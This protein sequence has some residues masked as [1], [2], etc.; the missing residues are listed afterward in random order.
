MPDKDFLENYNLYQ[1]FESEIPER[2]NDFDK[3]FGKPPI[4]MICDICK[5][6]QTFS[7]NTDYKKA[8]G[9]DLSSGSI[10]L[11]DYLCVG[12]SK[13]HRSF[14]VKVSDK[15]DYFMKVGQNPAI[16]ISI[17]K[18]LSKVLGKHEE[19]YRKGLINERQG[20]GIGA[21]A[22]YRRI[23]ESTIDELLN[24]IYD[25]VESTRKDEYRYSLEKVKKTT[26]ASEKISFVKDLLPDKLRPDGMNPLGIL[27][28]SLSGGIH[29]KSDEDCL[30]ISENIRKT[31]VYLLEQVIRSKQESKEFAESMRR[32]L[33]KNAKKNS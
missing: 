1:K 17:D 12:C 7:M 29:D 6:E 14:L 9:S 33:E 20:Y 3:T 13:F 27:Y 8:S 2:V 28:A 25:F 5:S 31:L 21:Y 26:V 19:L 30:E 10:F 22:Y 32:I 11:L 18:S 15:R 4:H 23:V 24:D 16:D